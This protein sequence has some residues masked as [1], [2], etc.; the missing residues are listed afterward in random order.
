MSREICRK[1]D[2]YFF[3]IKPGW[4]NVTSG[5]ANAMKVALLKHGPLSVAIDASHKT[6]R[7]TISI[8][9]IYFI[10]RP[11]ENDFKFF[12][13]V[14]QFPYSFYS[15]GV[16]YEPSCGS[17]V[18]SLDHAVGVVGYGQMNG[19]LYWLVKNS[20]SNLWGNDG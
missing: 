16:Y 5:D 10:F 6:F 13:F 8:I 9:I 14:F 1:I 19:Q 11:N 18:E 17:S 15:N 12:F 4:V 20:W 3:P 7:Y 2:Y